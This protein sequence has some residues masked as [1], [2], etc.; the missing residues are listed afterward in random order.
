MSGPVLPESLLRLMTPAARAKLGKAGRT[1]ADIETEQAAKNEKELQCQLRSLLALRHVMA[2]SPRFGKSSGI[3]PGWPDITFA[4]RGVPC[5][6]EVKY[7]R[8]GLE[9]V[10]ENLRPLLMSNGWRY[11]VIRSVDEGRAFLNLID[12]QP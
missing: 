1:M 3:L 10:Q 2:M 7:G 8:N 9:E 6:W 11:A 12:N 5:L 4:Y